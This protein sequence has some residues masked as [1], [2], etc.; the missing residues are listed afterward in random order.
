M[1]RPKADPSLGW[2]YRPDRDTL[3]ALT[4][5]R[6]KLK[7]AEFVEGVEK[8]HFGGNLAKELEEERR[9]TIKRRKKMATKV[10]KKELKAIEK[11]QAKLN[12]MLKRA[13]RDEEE[14]DLA[15][16]ERPSKSSKKVDKPTGKL[17]PLK[18]ICSEL[19][20][21]PKATRVKLRRLIE[22]GEIDFHDMS[23]RWEFTKSQ[24]A[25]IRALLE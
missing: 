23:Q 20:L 15:P 9:I 6:D 3:H 21:D 12:G 8:P 2:A 17:I 24:A 16:P 18:A 7:A 5:G 25:E 14:A 22:K 19:D 13:K 10:M 11:H 4:R 1:I